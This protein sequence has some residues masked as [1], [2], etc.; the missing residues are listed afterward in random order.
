VGEFPR[1]IL[2]LD[3]GSG[4]QDLLLWRQGEVMEN[5]IQMVLP[6][7][8]VLMARRVR[9]ATEERRP[10]HLAGHLMGGGPVAW[11][12]RDHLQAGLPVTA[13][14]QAA[15]TLH[16]DPGHVREMGVMV[17]DAPLQGALELFLGDVQRDALARALACFDA[18]APDL[19]CVAVQDHGHQPRG[20]NRAFRFLHWKK[21]LGAGGVMA[22]ALYEAPPPYLTRMASILSQCPGAMVMD[23]GMA[24]VHGALC[25]PWVRDR[26]EAGVLVVNLGN[27]HALAALVTGDRVWGLLEHHTGALTQDALARWMDR[28]RRRE[29]GHD[30]VLEDGGHGCAYHPEG[31]PQRAF[32][33]VAVTG[34]QRALALGLGWHLAAPFGNMM[35][36]GCYGLVR[37]FHLSRGIPWPRIQG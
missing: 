4:T 18:P 7:P 1:D 25:D 20:S 37:A 13:A 35:L 9:R 23:T 10:V 2:A 29:V 28:F 31:S 22:D 17:Q 34:P 19:W 3:V 26:A 11:A 5:C 36:T 27:Q 12:V 24:A 15:L 32:Q 30:E 21:F 8:T 14:P 16:D 33:A 6:S